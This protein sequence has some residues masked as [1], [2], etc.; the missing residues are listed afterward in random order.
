MRCERLREVEC[1]V[2]P[3]L[4]LASS[5]RFTNTYAPESSSP[6]DEHRPEG[7]LR[8]IEFPGIGLSHGSSRTLWND[9]IT[10]GL[11]HTPVGLHTAARST[12]TT[13]SRRKERE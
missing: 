4:L 3:R 13:S 11:V 12:K 8:L 6:T 5:S 9:A 2:P 10:F 7:T 1:F